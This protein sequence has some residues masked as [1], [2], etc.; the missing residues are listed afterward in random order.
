[1]SGAT[2]TQFNR[3]YILRNSIN[4]ARGIYLT[5][6]VYIRDRENLLPQRNVI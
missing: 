1:M 5:A 4:K 3:Y 6:T 2:L